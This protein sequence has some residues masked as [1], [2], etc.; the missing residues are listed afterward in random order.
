MSKLYLIPAS[1]LSDPATRAAADLATHAQQ[2]ATILRRFPP[3]Y[4]GFALA[5][6]TEWRIYGFERNQKRWSDGRYHM[7][8]RDYDYWRGHRVS[9]TREELTRLGLDEW[10]RRAIRAAHGDQ[11][12]P[13]AS[14]CFQ[15]HPRRQLK[16]YAALVERIAEAAQPA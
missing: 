11:F 10:D 2:L 6:T 7:L 12:A 9:F 8:N 13:M 3:L 16:R 1:K 5:L 4:H 14:D 15:D